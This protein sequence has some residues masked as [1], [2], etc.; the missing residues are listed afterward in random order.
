MC[1]RRATL[2]SR[3]RPKMSSLQLDLERLALCKFYNQLIINDF[4][5]LG[6]NRVFRNLLILKEPVALV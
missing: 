5:A 6:T 4:L 2:A 3:R 1:F